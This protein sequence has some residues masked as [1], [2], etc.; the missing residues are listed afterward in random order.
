MLNIRQHGLRRD[1]TEFFQNVAANLNVHLANM[2]NKFC[3]TQ[4]LHSWLWR[5]VVVV[6]AAVAVVE[7][8]A[9]TATAAGGAAA[10]TEIVVV[11]GGA[12]VVCKKM[13]YK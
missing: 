7:D 4:L 1:A 12:A 2:P 11:V 5:A 6:V 8:V 9:A 10:T 3:L 13:R